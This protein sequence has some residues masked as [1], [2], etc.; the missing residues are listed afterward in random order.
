MATEETTPDVHAPGSPDKTW[1]CDP[2]AVLV[3]LALVSGAGVLCFYLF[4]G[5]AN[6]TAW[7]GLVLFISLF[8]SL[9]FLYLFAGAIG[10]L[11]MTGM[12]VFCYG[13]TS[14]T[15][16]L[17]IRGLAAALTPA[18]EP[19]KPSEQPPEQGF[20]SADT[21]SPGGGRFWDRGDGAAATP[22]GCVAGWSP[23][24]EVGIHG[25]CQQH[26]SS[27]WGFLLPGFDWIAL[28]LAHRLDVPLHS[29]ALDCDG[30]G[31]LP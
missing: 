14:V 24:A 27:R 3:L 8:L 21:G 5:L 26:H 25:P 10:K 29:T 28:N 20:G 18:E 9:S 23:Q 31:L 1:I 19:K 13:F 30:P 11:K 17:G 2:R 15:I 22:C 4:V 16:L 12:V 7:K 6:S